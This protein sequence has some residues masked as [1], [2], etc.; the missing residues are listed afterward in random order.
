[1]SKVRGIR[2]TSDEEKQIDKFLKNNPLIDFSTIAR[3]SI[4]EFIRNPKITLVPVRRTPN[5]KEGL[6]AR[7]N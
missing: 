2:F 3:I 1:M 7:S 4:L 6:D 5:S